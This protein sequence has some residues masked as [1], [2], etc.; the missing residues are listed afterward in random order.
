LLVKKREQERAG[1][2]RREQ[3]RAGESRREQERAEKSTERRKKKEKNSVHLYNLVHGK[4]T[5]TH[6]VLLA[7]L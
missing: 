4:T 6:C 1:E 7:P 2:S 5:P 3:E